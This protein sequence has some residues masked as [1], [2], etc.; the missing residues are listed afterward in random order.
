M[1]FLTSRGI[2]VAAVDYRGSTGDGRAYRDLLRGAW[3]A[4]DVDDC[5]AFAQSL[6]ADGVVDG[7]RMAIRGGS[8]GGL[9]ALSALIR[10]RA[11]A[12]AVAWY[13]VTDMNGLAADTH[14]FE[15]R[16]LD[17]LVGPLPAAA[18]IYRD[19]SP[20]ARAAEVVGRVLLLQ[21]ADDPIVP[22]DQAERFA[23]ELASGGAEPELIVF[24]GES[25]GFRRAST[26]EAALEAELDFY[27][28]L[29]AP[30][31]VDGA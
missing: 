8:A 11:F 18:A 16:Y 19:R 27:R 2:A 17:R 20:I 12:G 31:G 10:S 9:T 6:A 7:D 4:G 14:D 24:A 21:G 23:A 26:I 3:G 25:H 1:Q 15:S 30:G 29:F 13:G 22:L 28:R 5:V